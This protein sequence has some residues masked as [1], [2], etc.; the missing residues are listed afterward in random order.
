VAQHRSTAGIMAT[1]QRQ[2][3]AKQR[4]KTPIGSIS[5]GA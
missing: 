2:A 4:S 1:W 3:D 5:S